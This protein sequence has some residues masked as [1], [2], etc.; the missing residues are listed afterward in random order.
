MILRFRVVSLCITVDVSGGELP[1]L[2]YLL[3]GSDST[4][5]CHSNFWNSSGAF[6]AG[7]YRS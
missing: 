2:Y 6:V 7:C 3:M 5:E 1:W 4:L